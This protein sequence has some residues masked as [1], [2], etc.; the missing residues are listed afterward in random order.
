MLLKKRKKYFGDIIPKDRL[1]AVIEVATD[2]DVEG[3]LDIV[4][5]AMRCYQEFADEEC[6]VDYSN[7]TFDTNYKYWNLKRWAK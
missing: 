1:Y 2:D 4:W 5:N 6:D 7:Y 3:L